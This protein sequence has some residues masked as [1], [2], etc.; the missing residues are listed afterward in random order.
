MFRLPSILKG[1]KRSKY[2]NKKVMV[3]NI[4]FDSKKEA[5]RFLELNYLHRCGKIKDLKLQPKFLL[6]KGFKHD[7]RKIRDIFYVAD[8]QYINQD[9]KAVVED[10]KGLRTSVYRLKK[11]LFLNIYR[12]DYIFIET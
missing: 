2:G 6:M 5:D 4:Q 7:K 12:K 9:G 11:K 8:F 3:K 10:V 1:N